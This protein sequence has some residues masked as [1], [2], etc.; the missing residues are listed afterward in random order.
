MAKTSEAKGLE[1]LKDPE[2]SLVAGPRGDAHSTIDPAQASLVRQQRV[3]AREARLGE[4][5]A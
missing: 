5:A 4:S 3:W 2:S 1:N